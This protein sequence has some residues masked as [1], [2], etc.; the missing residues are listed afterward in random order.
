MAVRRAAAFAMRRADDGLRGIFRRHLP[1]LMWTTIECGP[2]S[3]GV[4]DS[5]YLASGGAEGW[6]EHKATDA[7]AVKFRDYQVPWLERR[8]RLGGR[9]WVAVRRRHAGGPR[10]GPAVDELWMVPGGL[11]G[12][13]AREGLAALALG[14]R[15]THPSN[16][17][18]RWHGGPARWDW[19][20]VRAALVG[21]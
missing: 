13:L 15:D 17:G 21:T 1:D 9:V 18:G 5:N 2:V 8:A 6:V 7:W 11:A 16:T 4:A 14:L 3:P 20:A 10:R 12:A 19:D